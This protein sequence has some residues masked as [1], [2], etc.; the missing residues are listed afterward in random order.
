MVVC[1][2]ANKKQN[3]ICT[4]YTCSYSYNHKTADIF[5]CFCR[6]CSSSV[7]I[8]VFLMKSCNKDINFASMI[9]YAN[10]ALLGQ[11]CSYAVTTSYHI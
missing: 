7:T 4:N 1:D 11:S 9:L 8:Q 5:V 2:W 6:G 3:Q 10:L